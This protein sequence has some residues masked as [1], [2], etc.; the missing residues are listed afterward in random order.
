[1]N[2]FTNCERGDF[3]FKREGERYLGKGAFSKL[4]QGEVRFIEKH[5]DIS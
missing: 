4:S 5:E 1:M 3:L 2:R